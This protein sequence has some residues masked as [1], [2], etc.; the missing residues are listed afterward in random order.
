[1][2]EGV[3]VTLPGHHR[4]VEKK[5]NQEY[6]IH[7]LWAEMEFDIKY[8]VIK[9]AKLSG[10]E[11]QADK[12]Y[13]PAKNYQFTQS[14]EDWMLRMIDRAVGNVRSKL[15]NVVQHASRFASDELLPKM[16]DYDIVLHYDGDVQWLGSADDVMNNIHEYVVDYCISDF[17]EMD[18]MTQQAERMMSRAE[19]AL[20]NAYD[21]TN[22]VIIQTPMFIL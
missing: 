10:V 4:W 15:K 21:E 7:L 5:P 2:D 8:G 13:K 16:K 1:M 20:E 9:R 22:S 19:Q 12:K 3:K 6:C 11:A 14:D 17:L 18:G